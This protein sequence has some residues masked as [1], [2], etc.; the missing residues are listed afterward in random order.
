MIIYA[1]NPTFLTLFNIQ[2]I[3][4]QVAVFGILAIAETF[5]IIALGIDLSVGSIVAFIGIIAALTMG[6]TGNSIVL[7]VIV[8]LLV[9]CH[10]RPVSRRVRHQAGRRPVHH[11]TLGSLSIFRGAAFVLTRGGTPC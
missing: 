10:H 9:S 3:M 6:W 5:I 7:T 2:V 11:Y 4:R 8:A 1:L